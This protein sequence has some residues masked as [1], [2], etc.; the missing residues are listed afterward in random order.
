MNG[1]ELLKAAVGTSAIT[2]GRCIGAA[3]E[4]LAVKVDE[5]LFEGISP[6]ESGG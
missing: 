2:W 5:G 4:Y 6:Q 1:R 3:K